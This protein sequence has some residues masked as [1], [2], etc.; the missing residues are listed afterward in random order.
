MLFRSRWNVDTVLV[1]PDSALATGLRSSP[2]WTV[3]YE[4]SQAVIL[5]ALPDA[6]RTEPN[7]GNPTVGKPSL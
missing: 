7:K 4:D 5:S 1:P 2:G 6:I 3:S